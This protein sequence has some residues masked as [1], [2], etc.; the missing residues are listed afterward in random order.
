MKRTLVP[1]ASLKEAESRGGGCGILGMRAFS[2]APDWVQN[3]RRKDSE[4]NEGLGGGRGGVYIAH[5]NHTVPCELG[6]DTIAI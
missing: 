3:L 5:L 6:A 4:N 2:R 1:A